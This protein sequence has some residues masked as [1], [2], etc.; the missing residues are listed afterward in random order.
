MF[1]WC[2]KHC[3]SCVCCFGVFSVW[4]EIS[5]CLLEMHTMNSK[6][7][8]RS[9][10]CSL[11]NQFI[12][13]SVIVLLGW[14]KNASDSGS[15]AA[16]N[17]RWLMMKEGHRNRAVILWYS[18]EVLA[19]PGRMCVSGLPTSSEACACLIMWG[20]S[21]QWKWQRTT[22]SHSVSPFHSQRY[23][24]LSYVYPLSCIF[25]GLKKNFHFN[26]REFI[27]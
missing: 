25:I 4:Y 21:L 10:V 16:V 9:W 12:C 1:Y 17:S 5:P 18:A 6:T 22:L 2:C 24:L 3:F 7:I 20:P 26:V 19:Y 14:V 11:F 13:C 27:V 8:F 15:S 23:R